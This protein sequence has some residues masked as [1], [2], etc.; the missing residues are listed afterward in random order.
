MKRIHKKII[1]HT[2]IAVA[3]LIA[4]EL[5]RYLGKVT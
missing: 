1:T 3:I 5:I 2:I 4:L